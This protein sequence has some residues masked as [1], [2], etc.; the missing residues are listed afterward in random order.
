MQIFL[1]SKFGINRTAGGLKVMA[2]KFKFWPSNVLA[3][4]FEPAVR[5]IPNFE[6]EKICKVGGLFAKAVEPLSQ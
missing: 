4:T 3:I 6:C 5:L 1:H 2:K